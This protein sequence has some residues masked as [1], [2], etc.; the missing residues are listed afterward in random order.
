[1]KKFFAND[2]FGGDQDN[3]NRQYESAPTTETGAQEDSEQNH[4]TK[5]SCPHAQPRQNRT[6]REKWDSFRVYVA[7]A[8]P[9]IKKI[10]EV[11]STALGIVSAFLTIKTKRRDLRSAQR[12]SWG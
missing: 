5:H 6:W 8:A 9:I 10:A 1:M 4:D 3:A 12:F 11:V 7:E 2:I